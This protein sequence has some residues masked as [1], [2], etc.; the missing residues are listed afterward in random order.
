MK[1]ITTFILLFVVIFS[2]GQ[3][4][5]ETQVWISQQIQYYSFKDATSV[6]SYKLRFENSQ[7]IINNIFK[8]TLSNSEETYVVSYYIPINDL[9]SIRFEEKEHNSW[10]I[11]ETKSENKTIKYIPPSF[12]KKKRN[13]LTSM[14]ELPESKMR[15]LS[16]I[17]I[18]L[19][20]TI[21]E[22]N[23][24]SRLIKSF[25]HLISFYN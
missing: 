16:Q 25:D 1:S 22:D 11:I 13:G 2:Y 10:M 19:S 12:V 17:E 7:I 14:Y 5:E 23:I 24:K 4:K 21:S 8:R 15:F 3:S 9:L 6:N 20:N 18:L